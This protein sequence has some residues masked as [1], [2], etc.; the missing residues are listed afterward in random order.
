MARQTSNSSQNPSSEP[1]TP[2]KVNFDIRTP[3]QELEDLILDCFRIPLTRWTIIDEDNVIDQLDAIRE[4]VP[5]AIKQA[6]AILEQ[7]EQ[8]LAEANSQYQRMIESAQQRAAEILDQ[9][10]IIQQAEAEASQ[11]RQQVQQDC[12]QMQR[13]IMEDVEQMRQ[14]TTQE[15]DQYR[16][17]AQAEYQDMQKGAEEYADQRLRYIEQR[18]GQ[19]IQEFSQILQEVRNGRQ[20][21]QGNPPPSSTKALP[22]QLDP[23]RSKGDGRKMKTNSKR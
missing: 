19:T 15:I 13:K 3:I 7:K 20:Q 2:A 14:I 8:I 1:I 6:A 17:Q 22:P 18:L 16:Q 11:I 9:T 10:R 5:D 21:L 12:E 23:K 4:S